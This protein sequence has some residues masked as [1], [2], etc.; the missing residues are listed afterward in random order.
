MEFDG[1]EYLVRPERLAEIRERLRE[2][3]ALVV[4][5]S[6]RLASLFDVFRVLTDEVRAM[7]SEWRS[8]G[9][10][11][12]ELEE[13]GEH[14][15]AD[16]LKECLRVPLAVTCELQQGEPARRVRFLPFDG[17]RYEAMS[18]ADVL[19]QRDGR[20]EPAP[21]QTAALLLPWWDQRARRGEAAGASS[22]RG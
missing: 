8:T 13:L 21:A 22:G 9:V 4:G 2:L 19:F 11:V 1:L 7:A 10:F 18:R 15:L 14:R 17:L 20:W 5:E 3:V 16:L 12:A 6:E